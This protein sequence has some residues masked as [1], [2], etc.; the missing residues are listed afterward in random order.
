MQAKSYECN[1]ITVDKRKTDVTRRKNGNQTK[2]DRQPDDMVLCRDGLLQRNLYTVSRSCH[3][4][5]DCSP[6]DRRF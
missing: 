4:C 6:S 3:Q 1:R 2:T 5:C